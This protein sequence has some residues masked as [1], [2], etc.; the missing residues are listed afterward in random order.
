MGGA[1]DPETG[2][3]IEECRRW[4]ANAQ[5]FL[6]WAH[7]VG[8]HGAVAR[9][10]NWWTTRF[11]EFDYPFPA[12]SAIGLTVRGVSADDATDHMLP[13]PEQ[14]EALK[15]KLDWSDAALARWVG[16][17]DEDIQA[18]IDWSPPRQP[19]RRPLGGWDKRPGGRFGKF[20]DR[21]K[22]VREVLGIEA[23]CTDA[24]VLDY[25]RQLRDYVRLLFQSGGSA[26]L[27]HGLE[28]P[29]R[30]YRMPVGGPVA[31]KVAG[32]SDVEMGLAVDEMEAAAKAAAGQDWS[33][34]LR[35]LSG[36]YKSGKYELTRSEILAGWVEHGRICLTDDDALGLEISLDAVLSAPGV[37]TKAI[38]AARSWADVEFGSWKEAAAWLVEIVWMYLRLR[39]TNGQWRPEDE[40]ELVLGTSIIQRSA[41]KSVEEAQPEAKR[42]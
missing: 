21:I 32:V 42:N 33:C 39:E 37:D 13:G 26:R 5:R 9:P 8:V 19:R 30:G 4:I 35:N 28:T 18:V 2:S 3:A 23:P 10:P 22:F 38:L 12:I 36:V 20:S 11:D 7:E 25:L 24:E 29:A 31:D 6:A 34:A 15:S 14:F 40:P 41:K 17:L 16:A 1:V 27:G